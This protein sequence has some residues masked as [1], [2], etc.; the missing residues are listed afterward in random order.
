MNVIFI[1]V[2]HQDKYVDM[3]YLLLESI[4]LYGNLEDTTI[5]VYTSTLFMNRIKQY[6][7]FTDKIKFEINDEYDTIE[8]ACKA[9]LDLFDLSIEPYNKILYLD[10]DILI[11]DNKILL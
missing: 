8:K 9:R 2:F 11:K 7:L 10:T 6:H 5:L 1:C 3:F 4:L